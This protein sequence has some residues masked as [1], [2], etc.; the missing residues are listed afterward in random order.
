MK[1]KN[2]YRLTTKRH[3]ILSTDD[4]DERHDGM[5]DTLGAPVV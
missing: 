4:A 1:Q 2:K 3:E 5:T